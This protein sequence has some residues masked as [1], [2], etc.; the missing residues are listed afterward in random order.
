MTGKIIEFW[1]LRVLESFSDEK[2][3]LQAEENDI[4]ALDKQDAIYV[5]ERNP[6]KLK[7]IELWTCH[8]VNKTWKKVIPEA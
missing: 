6:R 8:P 4:R 1:V 2:Y 7:L 3:W 5:M